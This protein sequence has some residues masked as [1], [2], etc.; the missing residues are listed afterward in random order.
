MLKNKT[1][2]VFCFVCLFVFFVVVVVFGLF[3]CL[4]PLLLQGGYWR[5]FLNLF[6]YAFERQNHYCCAPRINFICDE[7]QL[8]SDLNTDFA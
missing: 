7:Q 1:A 2:F 8:S 5:Q 4:V 6:C 3:V